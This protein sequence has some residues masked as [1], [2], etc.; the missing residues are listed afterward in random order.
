MNGIAFNMAE[1]FSLL[2]MN[3]PVDI[4]YTLELNEWNNETNVQIRVIDM[5]LS[6]T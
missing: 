1:K 6:I 4:V 2:Q 3:E 5:K